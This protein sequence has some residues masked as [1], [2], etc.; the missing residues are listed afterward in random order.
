MTT[1][2]RSGSSIRSTSRQFAGMK[3]LSNRM[4]VSTAT[5]TRSPG[6]T[7][8]R[9]LFAARIFSAIVMP[10]SLP[11][12]RFQTDGPNELAPFRGFGADMR[13]KLLRR[14]WSNVAAERR[15][16]LARIGRGE[17]FR[18][19]AIQALDDSGRCRRRHEHAEPAARV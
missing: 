16:P 2:I 1:T 5:V 18:D 3:L 17:A 14:A 10:I 13:G 7:R 8:S 19:R 9:P 4:T 11:L 15:E 6:R 12:F